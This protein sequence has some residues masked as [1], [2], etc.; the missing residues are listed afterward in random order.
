MKK[1]LFLILVIT[2]LVLACGRTKPT[3]GYFVA[4]ESIL[5]PPEVAKFGNDSLIAICTAMPCPE[6]PG[7][8]EFTVSS[9]VP[10]CHYGFHYN[11]LNWCYYTDAVTYTP[12][13]TYNVTGVAPFTNL[14]FCPENNNPFIRF[15]NDTVYLINPSKGGA[16]MYRMSWRRFLDGNPCGYGG[17]QDFKVNVVNY[18]ID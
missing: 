7:Y 1:T 4:S 15:P 13:S 18:M 9:G 6:S 3:E 11:V 8:A 12:I 16:I 17:Y 5:K 14:T 10:Y 2:A